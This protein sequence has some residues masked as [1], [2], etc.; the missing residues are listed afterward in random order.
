MIARDISEEKRIKHELIKAKEEAEAANKTKSAFL[1]NMSHELRTPMNAII[2]IPGMLLKYNTDNLTE[3]QREGCRIIRESGQKL[4]TLINNILDLSKIE[5]GAINVN[6]GEF[7]ILDLIDDLKI[8]VKSLIESKNFKKN[9][10]YH[11]KT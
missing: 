9:R 2:G 10:V 5:A 11:K 3:K 1:A 8:F 7:S 6:L 4:L